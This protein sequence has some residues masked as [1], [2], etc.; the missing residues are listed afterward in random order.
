MADQPLS[1]ATHRR[2][3]GPLP[4]QLANG[5]R[6]H[7]SPPELSRADHAIRKEY[8]V[9]APISRRYPR[10]KGRFPTCYSPVRHSV[11]TRRLDLV[12]LA[13]VK[14]AASVHPEPGSNSPLKLLQ[15]CACSTRSF[16]PGWSGRTR[17]SPVGNRSGSSPSCVSSVWPFDWP[18]R[19]DGYVCGFF[20]NPYW[21]VTVSGFQG[22][23]AARRY[24]TDVASRCQSLFSTNFGDTFAR[25]LRCETPPPFRPG[26]S[27][28][29]RCT[30]TAG[31]APLSDRPHE[32]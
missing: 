19:C 17:L 20:T 30:S 26:A 24:I 2:L 10:E 22:S 32:A 4:H 7:P 27:V 6:G 13:C 14:H 12:R 1:S 5:P 18:S 25:L 15:A 9:L 11:F 31:P 29:C 3:G 28:P 23:G 8:P 21:L 16:G